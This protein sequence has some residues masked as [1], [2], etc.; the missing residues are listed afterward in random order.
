MRLAFN[1]FERALDSAHVVTA[2]L[3]DSMWRI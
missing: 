3:N 1:A 2:K